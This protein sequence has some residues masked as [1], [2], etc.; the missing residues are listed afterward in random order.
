MN[1][2]F[3]TESGIRLIR[4]KSSPN[5][6][7]A[8]CPPEELECGSV[9]R[10]IEEAVPASG[11]RTRDC[12]GLM[13]TD[14][15]C[16]RLR[17]YLFLTV[18]N[19]VRQWSAIGTGKVD[20]SDHHGAAQARTGATEATSLVFPARLP[21]RPRASQRRLRTAA[22]SASDA[23]RNSRTRQDSYEGGQAWD[24]A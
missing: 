19:G 7:L 24:P 22:R 8:A 2:R 5:H 4:L 1:S 6:R 15:S 3:L 23:I 11:C 10:K 12:R 17:S 20:G 16:E 18:R 9:V 21:P 13:A 14:I